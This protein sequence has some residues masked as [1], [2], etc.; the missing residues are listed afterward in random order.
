IGGFRSF[1]KYYGN[2]RSNGAVSTGCLL[3]YLLFQRGFMIN[4]HF[5]SIKVIKKALRVV[6]EA[7]FA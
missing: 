1:R 2:G 5:Y 4:S 7:F 3:I 6:L